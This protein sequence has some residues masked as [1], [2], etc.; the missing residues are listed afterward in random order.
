MAAPKSVSSQRVS[1][2]WYPF[3]TGANHRAQRQRNFD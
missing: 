3:R 1:A 2:V